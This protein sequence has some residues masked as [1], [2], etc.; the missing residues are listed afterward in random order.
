MGMNFG[1]AL[2]SDHASQ[3]RQKLA[4]EQD[5]WVKEQE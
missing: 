4:K 3:E 2:M 5:A 1:A